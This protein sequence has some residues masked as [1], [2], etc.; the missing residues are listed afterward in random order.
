MARTRLAPEMRRA[1]LV[2]SAAR[3]FAEHGVDDTAV[4]EIVS[5]AGV[6]QGTF[7][8]YFESKSDIVDAV[9]VTLSEQIVAGVLE[10]AAEPAAP[11]LDKLLRMRDEMLSAAGPDRAVIEFFHRPGNE[12]L[13]DRVS[14]DAM[15]R[16][17]PAL[18]RVI[19]QGCSEG[20]FRI[21]HPDDAARFIAAL[22]DVT[23]PFD[24]FAEP[25]R[26]GHHIEALTEFALRG[27]GVDEATLASS[28]ARGHQ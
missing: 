20:V 21:S 5:A 7:Y 12:A 2:S 6:A 10:I 13:H 11:A 4:S 28:L 9:V 16:T 17:V 25:E 8:L 1:E 18:E 15:R 19:L 23:D 24:V 27:L 26:L 14:R 22:T 3:L